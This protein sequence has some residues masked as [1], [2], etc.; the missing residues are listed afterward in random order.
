MLAG[1]GAT[2]QGN[3]EGLVQ[4]QHLD[5]SAPSV[6]DVHHQFVQKYFFPSSLSQP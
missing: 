4:G 2:D 1:I 5:S 6:A 3:Q